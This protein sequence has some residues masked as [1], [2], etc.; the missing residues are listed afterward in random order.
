MGSRIGTPKCSNKSTGA[1]KY[2][3]LRSYRKV[4]HA[5][6]GHVDPQ[7]FLRAVPSPLSDSEAVTK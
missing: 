3:K 1:A 4:A 6:N 5:E 2:G 7:A